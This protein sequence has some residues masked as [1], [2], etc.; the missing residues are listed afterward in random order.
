MAIPLRSIKYAAGENRTWGLNLGR[1]RRRSLEVS[2]WAGPLENRDRV[3]QAGRLVGLSVPPPEERLQLIPYG[4]SRAEQNEAP[5]WGGGADA[6]YAVTSE[7]ALYATANLTRFELS[8]P[9]KRPFFIEGQEL[10]RQRIQTR[11]QRNLGRSYLAGVVANRRLDGRDQGSASIDMNL[12]FTKTLGMTAQLAESYGL[13][14]RGTLAFFVRPS[15]DSPTR[16]FHVRYTHLG[17]RFA[18]NANVVGFI[19]D[20]D[21]REVDSAL[22]RTVWP[23][24]GPVERLEYDSNYNAYWSQ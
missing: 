14:G 19:R 21:R 17:D 10:F 23:N 3:S 13:H 5:S 24:K 4:L 12:F 11:A 20:D 16:H 6:R 18:D 1:S 9:E 22:A 2:F 8:L 15:Y 7:L